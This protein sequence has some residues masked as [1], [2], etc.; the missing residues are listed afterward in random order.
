MNLS[1]VGRRRIRQGP[2]EIYELAHDQLGKSSDETSL[3]LV[4]NY[5]EETD[6]DREQ[7]LKKKIV[8]IK[9]SRL[10]QDLPELAQEIV[11]KCKY[12]SNSR[13]HEV[14]DII[15]KLKDQY[16]AEVSRRGIL[17]SSHFDEL[18]SYVE[19]LYEVFFF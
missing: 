18:P 6:T 8:K 1:P 12:I 15:S 16:I 19:Q 11:Q 2:I 9:A 3:A 13:I 4:V 7:V 14:E 17:T 5:F 10:D